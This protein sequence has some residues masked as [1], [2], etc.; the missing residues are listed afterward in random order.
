MKMSEAKKG[1]EIKLWLKKYLTE[2]RRDLPF[3]IISTMI[4]I[5]GIAYVWTQL[6]PLPL[7]IDA[8][9]SASTLLF[10]LVITYF[11][12]KENAETL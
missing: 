4:I 10:I 2:I 3:F 9:I 5:V 11:L 8:F 1:F 12:G 7:Y 6:P